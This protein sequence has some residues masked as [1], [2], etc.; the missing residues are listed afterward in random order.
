MPDIYDPLKELREQMKLMKQL[1]PFRELR[2]QMELM[3]KMDPFKELRE[4]MN[5]I[6][7]MDPFKEI[8]EQINLVSQMDPF[9]E[10]R[11]TLQTFQGADLFRDIKE[12]VYLFHQMDPL[13]DM[14]NLV[15]SL[16]SQQID[17]KYWLKYNLSA[18]T[19]GEAYKEVLSIYAEADVQ[20]SSDDETAFA[21][22]VSGIRDKIK[23]SPISYL[24]LEFYL[25]LLI[26]ILVLVYSQKMS[27]QSEQRV[28][29]QM[30]ELHQMLKE[31]MD[32][33]DDVNELSSYYVVERT[34]DLYKQPN[35]KCVVLASKIYP[36]QKVR[37]IERGGKWIKI[38]YFNH[39]QNIHES[40]WCL[41]KYTKLFRGVKSK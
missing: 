27:D 37:L 29:N 11:A 15:E 21:D 5:L 36:N 6:R 14:R 32:Q 30:I 25:S 7:Q 38:E 31:H 12:S 34:T 3:R 18:N 17:M 26:T 35:S 13:K 19:L 9:K 4:Q 1:D 8:K 41:K 40:G 39:S 28:T 2:E 22:I 23:H 16:N 24:S 10:L 20:T 33:A